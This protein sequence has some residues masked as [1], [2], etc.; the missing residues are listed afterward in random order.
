MRNIVF[1]TQPESQYNA[2]NCFTE[3]LQR[4]LS[5]LGVKNIAVDLN[6]MTHSDYQLLMIK[7]RPDCTAGF[8]V[9]LGYQINDK[10]RFVPHLSL[11]VDNVCYN[12]DIIYTYH[13]V[14]SF[15]DEDSCSFLKYYCW[16][17]SIFLPHAI[18]RELLDPKD[19]DQI[20]DA[21][22]DLDL[23]MSG[24]YYDY[25]S[26]LSKWRLEL[27]SSSFNA[28]LESAEKVLHNVHLSDASVCRTCRVKQGP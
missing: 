26:I 7:E 24:S 15:V 3:G 12:S 14:P 19:V 20:K 23:V 6:K 27:S 17:D 4:A 1:F 10:H 18:D 21:K 2:L 11:F 8:N 28:L 5:R 13:V 25:E 9:L 16:R 22:R